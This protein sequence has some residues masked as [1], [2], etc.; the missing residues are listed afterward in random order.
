MNR[1]PQIAI[2]SDQNRL[3]HDLGNL[4]CHDTDIGLLAPEIA[5]AIE[6]E[7]VVE[8]VEQNDVA[9]EPNIRADGQGGDPLRFGE[10]N[11]FAFDRRRE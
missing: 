11:I 10:P 9:L 4:L 2:R 1:N 3:G 7:A 6:A 5:V 8:M